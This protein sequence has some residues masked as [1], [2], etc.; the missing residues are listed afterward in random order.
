MWS[1]SPQQPSCRSQRAR[2]VPAITERRPMH[3]R[4]S[5]LVVLP[6]PRHRE[7]AAAVLAASHRPPGT[8][9]LPIDGAWT[10]ASTISTGALAVF[11]ALKT[12]RGPVAPRPQE[13]TSSKKSSAIHQSATEQCISHKL[14]IMTIDGPRCLNRTDAWS[15]LVG[16]VR[17]RFFASARGFDSPA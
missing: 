15:I 12:K 7:S 11:R 4:T 6:L 17:I 16:V 1:I 9:V 2:A 3:V 8:P 13:R 14:Q 5:V 10:H